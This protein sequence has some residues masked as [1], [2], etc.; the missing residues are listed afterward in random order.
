MDHNF[1]NETLILFASAVAVVVLF[2][3]IK[4]P[5][6]LG[7]LTLGLLV[8]PYG[9]AL[10]TDVEHTRE[11]A[12]FGVVFLLFTIGL[13]FSLPLLI[14]MRGAVL[15]LGGGQVLLSTAVTTVL[16]MYLGFSLEVS[17]VL[18][19]VVA[20]S[21]TALV[22]KQLTDQVELHSRHGRNA[23]GI[24]L[25]QDIMVIPFLILV[26]SL[27]SPASDTPVISVLSALGQGLIALVVIFGLGRWVLRPLFRA[28]ARFRSTE[29]FTLT[30]LTVALGSAWITHQ[31]GLSLALGAF[32][33]G[34]MLGETEF[35]HQLEAEIRPFRDVLLGLFFVTIGMLLNIGLLP[36]I[37]LWVLVFL[38][39]I[40]A[41]KLLLITALCRFA[42]WDAAVSLR[43]GMVLAH[44][45]EFGFA[46]LALALSANLLPGNSGQ[47]VLA[48]LLI[49][50]AFAPLL[51]KFNGKLVAMILPKATALSPQTIKEQISQTTDKLSEH[52]IICGYG[53]VGQNV[54]NILQDE[55]INFFAMDLDPVLVQN[56]IQ[57]KD[58][59]TYGDSA[60]IDLLNAAGLARASALVICLNE[61]DTSLKIIHSVRNINKD[62][63]ILVRTADDTH[64]TKLQQAGANEIIPETM[65]ASLMLS[66]H[67]LM[68]L[69]VPV[70]HV[71]QKIYK[72]R[73]GRYELLRRV[74]PGEE[75]NIWEPL[76]TEVLRAIELP[77][78][79]MPTQC[80]ISDLG[81]ADY[82]VK[83]TAIQQQD[84][85]INNPDDST[86]VN[87]GDTLILFGTPSDIEEAEIFLLTKSP[88]T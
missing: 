27:S 22:V 64:L 24:L 77:T 61:V 81:L 16:A 62:V 88:K 50:M 82:H 3:R 45:G 52:V 25:F 48:T 35:R 43:T 39:G 14:R 63:P 26:A 83:V 69:K 36:E 11:F 44:G 20:M 17:L 74:F 6:I 9:F 66:S 32:I 7:Y 53:R 54:G 33:A 30:A 67:L 84:A 41:F 68:M 34:M 51:I 49:S 65:E 8:G 12:E 70:S 80:K 86:L 71:F 75:V 42:G 57:A 73:K 18:G 87:P 40:V 47:I 10:I 4:L 46:I 1:L 19:G 78:D 79:N 13:E 85:R 60:N 23:M 28:V 72:I 55:K 29:L 37:W 38:F 59:V 2:L 15:G 31:L 21:S 56:A 5:P 76:T 58:P